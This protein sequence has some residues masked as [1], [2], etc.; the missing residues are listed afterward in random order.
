MKKFSFNFG[1]AVT[2]IV[3]AAAFLFAGCEDLSG[4]KSMLT[5]QAAAPEASP[6]AGTVASGTPVS[7]STATEGAAIYYTTDGNTPDKNNSAQLYTSGTTAITISAATTLKAIA[8]KEGMTDSAVLVAAYT[9]D[10]N[11]V[12]MPTASPGAGAVESGATVTLSTATEGAA[13]YYTTDGNTPDKTN[14]AQLYTSGTTTITISADITLKAIAVKE[15]MTDSAVLVAAYT[16]AAEQTPGPG[17]GGDPTDPPDEPDLPPVSS[18]DVYP[19]AVTEAK[20]SVTETKAVD[21]AHWNW[22]LGMNAEEFTAYLPVVKTAAQALAVG[23]ES[24]G[25]VTLVTAGETINSVTAGE[26]LAIAAVDMEDLVWDGTDENGEATRTFTLNVSEDGKA[27]L[28]V[29]VNLKLTL[30]TDATIYHKVDGKWTRIRDPQ[31]TQAEIDK[32]YSYTGSANNNSKYGAAA[33]TAGAVKDLQNA[34]AWVGLNAEAGSSGV[35][36]GWTNTDVSYT[37][38]SEY[39]IFIKKNELISKINLRFIDKTKTYNNANYYASYDKDYVALELY[40]AGLPHGAGMDTERHVSL[41]HDW[42]TKDHGLN[43]KVNGNNDRYGLISLSAYP[44]ASKHHILALGKNITIDGRKWNGSSFE[45]FEITN[46]VSPASIDYTLSI[47]S[48]IDMNK[49][50][51]L[52][53]RPYSK[54]T[55]YLS[56]KPFG[57][58]SRSTSPAYIYLL[59]NSEISGNKVNNVRGVIDSPGGTIGTDF[60]FTPGAIVKDNWDY[61]GTKQMNVAYKGGDSTKPENVIYSWNTD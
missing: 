55:G 32:Q 49:N 48:L 13:I 26:T 42:N 25:K 20:I 1:K 27:P 46:N 56:N 54:V 8:V 45:D 19:V 44:N 16:I 3:A 57:T 7:L 40:G 47:R 43:Y 59:D 34:I 24:T 50:G 6:A 21:G 33:L 12:A 11:M 38:Y 52:I 5:P 41:N 61:E 23:T 28:T 36:S 53:M 60:F 22:S 37:G 15:G 31:M 14:T 39:R 58:V 17:T 9:I 35:I 51:V 30:P 18:D 29:T 2:L 4:L 10:E